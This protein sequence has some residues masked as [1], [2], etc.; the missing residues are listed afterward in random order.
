MMLFVFIW[1]F[2]SKA[3]DSMTAIIVFLQ[4]KIVKDI[5]AVMALVITLHIFVCKTD[6]RPESL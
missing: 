3:V 2:V 6:M 1:G 5:I 4:Q